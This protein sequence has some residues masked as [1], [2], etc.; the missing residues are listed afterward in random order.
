MSQEP[1]HFETAFAGA[2]P[3]AEWR[4][5]HVVL[6]V[7]G[8]AD[9]VAMLRAAAATKQRAGGAG[10]LFAA[11]LNHAIRPTDALADETWLAAL[12]ERL[13]VHLEVGR[14]DVSALAAEQGDGLEAAA[15]AARYKFLRESAERLGAR[16]VA[17]AHTADDQVETVLHRLLRGTGVAG[18]AGIPRFRLLS[19]TV[20]LVR[21]LLTVHRAD[22]LTYLAAIGQDYRTDST[23]I[24]PRF[25]RNRLRHDL[26]PRLRTEYN[27]DVDDALLRLATQAD[28]SQQLIARLARDVC[29][30]GM[31]IS[32]GIIAVDC[33]AL[34]PEPPVLIREACKTAWGVAG[35]PLQN[36]GFDEWCQ[37]A[38]LISD[39]REGGS[40]NL[41][42]GIVARSLDNRVEIS[43]ST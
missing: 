23:N 36:M 9:S 38:S 24:D 4:D 21:P 26:L 34:A 33:P 7:S 16:F 19:P 22:V 40:L 12:C 31:T 17:V 27:V 15:R 18:L 3:E 1:L 41:P 28:E 30:R 43:R 13:K 29:E 25:T 20:T 42:G 10:R 5:V 32:A 39:S 8:G 35:W 37:L 11:H 6:A 14:R 2:W